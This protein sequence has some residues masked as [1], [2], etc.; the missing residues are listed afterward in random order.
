MN[1]MILNK[2][3]IDILNA[4]KKELG[5]NIK[6]IHNKREIFST[7]A[8]K[9]AKKIEISNKLELLI[10]DWLSISDEI[11]HKRLLLDL[12]VELLK[13]NFEKIK[14]Y[15][16]ILSIEKLNLELEEYRNLFLDHITAMLIIDYPSGNIIHANKAACNL[17]QYDYTDFVKKNISEL[18]LNKECEVKSRLEGIVKSEKNRFILKH[19]T[20]TGK[21]I[22]V[23]V[24]SCAIVSDNNIRIFSIVHDIKERLDTKLKLEQQNYILKQLY[25]NTNDGIALINHDG[26]VIDANKSFYKLFYLTPKDLENR[27]LRDIIVP[28]ESKENNKHVAKTLRSEKELLTETIRQTKYGERLYLKIHGFPVKLNNED[29][30]YVL[31]TDM[32]QRKIEEERIKYLSLHDELTG[33]CN[34]R[35]FTNNL[36]MLQ[37]DGITPVSIIIGDVDN[38]KVIN[39]KHGHKA[40]DSLLVE[41]ANII[42]KTIKTKEKVFRIGG[43]EFAIVLEGV[44]QKEALDTVNKIK[45]NLTKSQR[46]LKMSLGVATKTKEDEFLERIVSKADKMMYL[47]KK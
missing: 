26:Y 46:K 25:D 38:L 7:G 19:F 41:I 10:E 30:F 35:C 24:Y 36:N 16:N 22:D 5:I 3:V 37:K 9:K 4:F 42:L 28:P 45:K 33:L 40:G 31:Y 1:N 39:D 44:C 43:D 29:V 18:S 8:I 15:G 32:T 14:S 13:S 6:I 2:E 17:Y 11:N 20:S 21:A 47:E 12:L 34:R 23:E 27:R